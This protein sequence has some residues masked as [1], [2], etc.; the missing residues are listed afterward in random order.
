MLVFLER[1]LM[2][3]RRAGYDV[4]RDCGIVDL[5]ASVVLEKSLEARALYGMKT[6]R[7]EKGEVVKELLFIH[8]GTI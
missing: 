8:R 6:G 2:E 7:E 3:G 5:F 4:G 1:Q